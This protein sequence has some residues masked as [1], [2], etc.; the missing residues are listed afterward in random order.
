MISKIFPS[1]SFVYIF[2][3]V[4]LKSSDEK[5]KRKIQQ[6]KIPHQYHHSKTDF[7]FS[8]FGKNSNVSKCADGGKVVGKIV[9]LENYFGCWRE[10]IAFSCE[11][12]KHESKF[13]AW[14]ME[15]RERGKMRLSVRE[16]EFSHFDAIAF[17]CMLFFIFI[18]FIFIFIFLCFI[19]LFTDKSGNVFPYKFQCLFFFCCVLNKYSHK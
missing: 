10:Q 13:E 6:Q 14:E 15:K 1:S 19:L 18:Y 16:Y 11:C 9:I 2:F 3:S 4:A 17:F 7:H 8:V 5:S 12:G